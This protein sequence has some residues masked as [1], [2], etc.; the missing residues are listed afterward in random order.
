[1]LPHQPWIHEGV[2]SGVCQNSAEA[3]PV[4]KPHR[5]IDVCPRPGPG[6]LV[7]GLIANTHTLYLPALATTDPGRAAG[8]RAGSS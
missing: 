2:V 7:L 8:S 1:M 4:G 3:V 6:S 5:G